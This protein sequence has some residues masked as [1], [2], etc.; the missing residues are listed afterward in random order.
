[1]NKI[2]L[3]ANTQ[4]LSPKLDA[5]FVC[6]IF[7]ML[8]AFPLQSIAKEVN[9][10]Q[11][12]ALVDSQNVKAPGAL[13]SA[14][15]NLISK[16][17]GLN[18]E[19]VE[20]QGWL[21]DSFSSVILRHYFEQAPRHN[22]AEQYW[23][24][25]VADENMLRQKIVE[26]EIP[27]WPNRRSSMLVWMVS[28]DE[29]GLLSFESESGD[30][31]YWLSKWLENKGVPA[32][33]Y[34]VDESDLMD[35]SPEDVKLL[36]PDVIDY[37]HQVQ[38]YDDVLLVYVRDTGLGFSYRMGLA[39]AGEETII[40][41]RQFVKLSQGFNHLSDFVQSHQAAN[42]Q[43]FANELANRTISVQINSI[44][45]AD[46]MLMI[47]NYLNN[48]SLINQWQ[49]E[50]LDGQV[51]HLRLEISVLAETFARFVGNESVLT[52]LPLDTGSSMIFSA[53]TQ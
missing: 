46:Q 9:V 5:L 12:A 14:M 43:I 51:L 27:I 4:I 28:E 15:F 13:K 50:K 6:L 32:D 31:H 37:L 40:K 36:N 3:N 19:A 47:I 41:H 1:M 35:F 16:G 44:Y 20:S 39:K 29:S 10:N 26:K 11:A 52:Y 42:Q 18:A 34:Q 53:Q 7:C 48:Q 25:V 23:L 2:P 22:G 8:S 21:D 17:S 24:H 33:F 45:N 30:N 49:I 38:Q